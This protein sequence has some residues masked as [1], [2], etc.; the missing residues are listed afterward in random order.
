MNIISIISSIIFILDT[1][2]SWKNTMYHS[3]KNLHVLT[4]LT[5]TSWV[6]SF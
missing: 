2:N 5:I 1:K 6:V 4:S 3:H